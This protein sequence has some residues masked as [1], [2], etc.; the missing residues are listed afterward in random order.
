MAAP[1]GTSARLIRIK[2][3]R[4]EVTFVCERIDL[5]QPINLLPRTAPRHPAAHTASP[6]GV[7]RASLR[8]VVNLP[9]LVLYAVGVSL[10][11][12]IF[13]LVGRIAGLSG[14]L[15]PL[16]FLTAGVIVAFTA[17]SFAELSSR[18]PHAAGE[19][20]YVHAAF[21]QRTLA[22]VVGLSVAIAGTISAAA[23]VNGCRA[24]VQQLIAAPDWTIELAIIAVMTAIAVWGVTQS[25]IATGLVT[26]LEAGTLI[27]I[28]SVALTSGVT[29]EP[30]IVAT[31]SSEGIAGVFAALLLAIFAFIGFE[32]AVN[33][34]EEV[35]RPTRTIP[36]ALVATLVIVASLYALVSAAAL[37]V[38]SPAA[39]AQAD[40]PLALVYRLATGKEG[41]FLNGLAV[42]ATINGVLALI[43]MVSRLLFGMAADGFLP[44][45]LAWVWPRTRTPLVATLAASAT[46]LLLALLAPIEPLARASSTVLL[47]VFVVVNAALLKIKLRR[48]P[49]GP[50]VFSV[51]AWVPAGGVLFS[52]LPVVWEALRLF[53]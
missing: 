20:A 50:G 24:Y 13:V 35:R 33:M 25:M 15:A 40:A 27:W 28:A 21:G 14:A 46:V 22:R 51:P 43:V 38:A 4:Q 2:D 41:A 1:C 11:A 39:L 10:G 48:E 47:L 36:L 6:D 44:P 29:P 26:I 12:G 45:G 16:T 52:L 9:A 30:A 18:L 34:A 23:I 37:S 5:L 32:S 49:V 42:T 31:A 3:T 8:R 53:H 19:A 7:P 17:F